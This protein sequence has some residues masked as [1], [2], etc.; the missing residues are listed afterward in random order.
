LYKSKEGDLHL[1]ERAFLQH[2]PQSAF[3]DHAPQQL[4]ADE[5]LELSLE[6]LAFDHARPQTSPGIVRAAQ[7]FYTDVFQ[8]AV[9][10]ALTSQ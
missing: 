9:V 8:S 1:R 4:E 5:E 10:H 2:C 7:D 3:I 6:A